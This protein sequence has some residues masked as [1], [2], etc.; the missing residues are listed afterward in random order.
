MSWKYIIAIYLISIFILLPINLWA[1]KSDAHT[2]SWKITFYRAITNFIPDMGGI[3]IIPILINNFKD[4]DF[5]V[6]LATIIFLLL[7][8]YVIKDRILTKIN[9]IEKQ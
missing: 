6:I 9:N 4:K 8:V 7:F 1:I 5:V 3:L 2:E